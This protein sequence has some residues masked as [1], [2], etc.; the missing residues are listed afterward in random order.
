MLTASEVSLILEAL[1]EKYGHDYS[2][3]PDYQA[4]HQEGQQQIGLLQAKLSLMLEVLTK[5]ESPSV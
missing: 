1:S 5:L 4:P 3:V 2:N